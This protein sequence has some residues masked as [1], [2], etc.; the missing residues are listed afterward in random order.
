MT[1]FPPVD[2]MVL[3]AVLQTFSKVSTLV[4]GITG[5]VFVARAALLIIQ[6]S[7]PSAYGDLLRDTIALLLALSVFPFVLKTVIQ[8][9]G[10][11]AGLIHFEA[12]SRS[13]GAIDQLFEE[14]G[15]RLPF[16]GAMIGLG[17]ITIQYLLKAVFSLL[18]GLLS[19]AAPLVFISGYVLGTGLGAQALGSSLIA[20]SLWPVLWNTVGLLASMLWPSFQETSLASI[21]FSFTVLILQFASPFFCLAILRQMAPQA[22]LRGAASLGSSIKG[23]LK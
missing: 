4:I 7:A 11:L 15:A 20:L 13:S 8:T 6:V 10:E 5:A 2:Q 21:V 12:M 19:V 9:S 23:G 17:S 3:D 22:A 18:V 16:F 1:T 14:M